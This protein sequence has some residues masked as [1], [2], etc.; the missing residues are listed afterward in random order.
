MSSAPSPLHQDLLAAFRDSQ[1]DALKALL[2]G[3]PF[4]AKLVENPQFL[5]GKATH[6]SKVLFDFD[7]G[8]GELRIF[9]SPGQM[10]VRLGKDREDVLD[11]IREL[12]NQSIGIAKRKL[13][14]DKSLDFILPVVLRQYHETWF[15]RPSVKWDLVQVW[16]VLLEDFRFQSELQLKITDTEALK[17]AL[18]QAS[19]GKTSVEFL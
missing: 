1:V 5:G 8:F 4:E 11:F 15:S 2:R 16:D 10:G 13:A 3:Y 19:S 12:L 6:C 7:F 9:F 18:H 17:T 14:D